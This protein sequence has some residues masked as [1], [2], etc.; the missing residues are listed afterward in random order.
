MEPRLNMHLLNF[1]SL[2]YGMRQSFALCAVLTWLACCIIIAMA[3]DYNEYAVRSDIALMI[4]H[5]T[6]CPRYSSCAEPN[7]MTYMTY[8]VGQKWHV[9]I[10]SFREFFRRALFVLSLRWQS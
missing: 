3:M 8:T 5:V 1:Q 6:G 10:H 7:K 4:F 2:E 9:L